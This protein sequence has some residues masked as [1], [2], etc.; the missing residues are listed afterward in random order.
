MTKSVNQGFPETEVT[1]AKEA[2]L[3]EMELGRSQD[4]SLVSQLARNAL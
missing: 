1:T 2:L 3:K 4:G